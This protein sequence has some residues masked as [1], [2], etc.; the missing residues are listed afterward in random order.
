MRRKLIEI[1]Y[2]GYA[3]FFHILYDLIILNNRAIGVYRHIFLFN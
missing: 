3:I 1:V 2:D